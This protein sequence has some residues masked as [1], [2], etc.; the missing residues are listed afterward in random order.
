MAAIEVRLPSVL[1]QI[2]G[3]KR[4]DIE[5]D[6]LKGGIEALLQEM[7]ELAVHLFDETGELRRHVNCFHNDDNTRWL[8]DLDRPLADGDTITIMQSVSGGA[9]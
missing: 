7:P 6:T 5:A 1:A 9:A 4:L 2:V 8:E 3:R